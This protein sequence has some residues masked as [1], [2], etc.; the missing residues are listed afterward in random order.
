MRDEIDV[1]VVCPVGAYTAELA[2]VHESFAAE[3]ARTSY[4]AEFIYVLDGPWTGAER[5][6]A[7]LSEARF[8]VRVFRM[9][10]GFGEA[11]AMQ[12]GFE[13]SQGRWILTIPDRP[14]IDPAVLRSVLERLA[15][16]RQVVVTRRDPRRDAL[17]NRL[18]SRV[19]HGLVRRV[20]GH[21]FGDLSCGVRGL[22][23][24]AA[25]K[26]D[27]YGDQHRF[28]PILALRGGYTVEEIAAPQHPANRALR[29]RGPGVYVRRL[30]DV[31]N[32]YF[33]YRFTRKPLRF[34]GLIGSAIG[35]IGAVVC[36]VLAAQRLF[37]AKALADRP[38]LLL[39]VLLIVLGVQITSIGLLGE[40]IIFLSSRRDQPEAEEVRP[41][42]TSAATLHEAG[43]ATS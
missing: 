10:R 20:S 18:Q 19:F 34:F 21:R 1:S 17:F 25:L 3:L 36:A 31:L 32:I 29:L 12:Y 38:M 9:A 6:L 7:G 27:L 43:R 33:L 16:G 4:R 28:I 41:A 30:L 14:Q 2:A 37:A 22:T 8:P 5:E 15:A 11:T 42:E 26:L 39:G 13:R 24:D 35:G 23:R 40:I